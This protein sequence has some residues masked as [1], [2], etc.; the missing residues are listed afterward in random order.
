M[1]IISVIVIIII[2][3]VVISTINRIHVTAAD[4]IVIRHVQRF[5]NILLDLRHHS[6]PVLRPVTRSFLR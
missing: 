2:I 1:S 6:Q 5:D 3:V 4:L